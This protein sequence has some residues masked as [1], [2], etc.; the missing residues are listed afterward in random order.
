P[1]PY[2]RIAADTSPTAIWEPLLVRAYLHEGRAISGPA[3][4]HQRSAGGSPAEGKS[5][6]RGVL[7]AAVC[8]EL[9]PLLPCVLATHGLRAATDSL[10]AMTHLLG[11]ALTEDLPGGDL[12][13]EASYPYLAGQGLFSDPEAAAEAARIARGSLDRV[14]A[15]LSAE[16]A[17]IVEIDGDQ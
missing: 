9:Q 1:R 14:L 6:V 3:I 7:G 4:R 16:G 8:A 17:R 2:E 15:D 12:L 10:G 11:A 5:F 13:A